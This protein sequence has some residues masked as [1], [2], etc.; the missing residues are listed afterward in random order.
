MAVNHCDAPMAD[1]L[2]PPRYRAGTEG[3]DDDES[4]PGE[5]AGQ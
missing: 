5:A 4:S 2:L 1:G 3:G